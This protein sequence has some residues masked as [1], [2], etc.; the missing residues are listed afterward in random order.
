MWTTC[1]VVNFILACWKRPLSF[2]PCWS[3]CPDFFCAWKSL[4]TVEKLVVITLQVVVWS[5]EVVVFFFM[6]E[7]TP[8][9]N[10]CVAKKAT[11]AS[12]SGKITVVLPAPAAFVCVN[13]HELVLGYSV[14]YLFATHTLAKYS[15]IKK[16]KARMQF[17]W[18]LPS[19][20]FAFSIACLHKISG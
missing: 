11:T 1:S 7:P 8:C 18:G 14:I 17:F 9:A 5:R 12:S 13:Q 19:D 20:G 3:I 6:E 4:S 2:T 16:R 10:D 15:A